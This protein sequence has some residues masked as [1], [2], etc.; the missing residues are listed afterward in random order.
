MPVKEKARPA[1]TAETAETAEKIIAEITPLAKESYKRTL[2]R[3]GIAEPVLGVS[4]EELKKIQKRVK[5]N[6]QLAL[7]LYDTGIYDAMYLAGLI[8]DDQQMTKRD[9]ERWVKRANAA[10]CGWAV[11]WVASE[12]QHG[13]ELGLKWIDSKEEKTAIAGWATLGSL[14][15][16][17]DDADLDL[18]ELKRLLARIE[19]TIDEQSDKVRYQM[20]SFVIAVGCYVAPL[21]ELARQTAERI[22][23]V[24]V[25]MG[26]TACKVPFAPDYIRKVEAR[27]TIGKKRKSA[28]C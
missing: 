19:K 18:A 9:L 22:G 20:N 28:K 5:K 21:T 10:L 3:H 7:D 8:A 26:D 6:Y 16:I 24:S 11:A 12:S 4:I 13:R 1:K 25:D 27:G 17:T 15:S 23:Q 14:V 2:L